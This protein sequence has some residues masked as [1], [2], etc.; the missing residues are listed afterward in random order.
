MPVVLPSRVDT[1]L[2]ETLKKYAPVFIMTQFNHVNEVTEESIKACR[3]FIDSGI[4]VFNQSVLLR[5]VNDSVQELE[6]LFHRLISI[7]VKPYYLFQG[8]LAPGTAHLRVPLKRGL[9]IM[10]ELRELLSGLSLPVYAVDLP[11]GGGRSLLPKT[12]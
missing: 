2:I 4:P 11:G 1:E 12:I 8:D 6:R 3:A 10:R 7:R 5:G 9:M